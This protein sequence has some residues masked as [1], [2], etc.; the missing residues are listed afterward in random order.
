MTSTKLID[1]VDRSAIFSDVALH[2][3]TQDVDALASLSQLFNFDVNSYLHPTT[4]QSSPKQSIEDTIAETADFN[5]FSTTSEP[6]KVSLTQPVYE[7]PLVNRS[8]PNEYY[9][10]NPY[11]PPTPSSN[12]RN[13]KERMSKFAAV[14]VTASELIESSREPLVYSPLTLL[15]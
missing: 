1:R 7:V 6:V 4:S 3:T 13:D 10:T 11:C 8:R 2:A 15:T 14:A 5:L 12:F 9:F